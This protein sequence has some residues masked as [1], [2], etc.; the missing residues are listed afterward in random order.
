MHPTQV[1]KYRLSGNRTRS[2]RNGLFTGIYTEVVSLRDFCFSLKSRFIPFH[3]DRYRGF[4]KHCRKSVRNR[5][6]SLTLLCVWY[7][8]S[9]IWLCRF[10]LRSSQFYLNT[11]T[12]RLRPHSVLVIVVKDFQVLFMKWLFFILFFFSLS[13]NSITTLRKEPTYTTLPFSLKELN[14][15]F[16]KCPVPNNYSYSLS[17]MLKGRNENERREQQ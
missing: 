6:L 10:V 9:P 13:Q 11:L 16:L 14:V 17:K 4:Y 8:A 1:H 7:W 12:F 2:S 3:S 5:Q 15:F